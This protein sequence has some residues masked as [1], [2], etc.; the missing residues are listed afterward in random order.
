MKRPFQFSLGS[1]SSALIFESAVGRSTSFTRQCA[2]SAGALAAA[3]P[4]PR[5]AGAGAAPG[6]TNGPE[7]VE[8]AVIA[9]CGVDMA[10]SDS[11]V[12]AG[13]AA[14]AADRS[15]KPRF[16]MESPSSAFSAD[17]IE[18]VDAAVEI[19]LR[20]EEVAFAVHGDAVWCEYESGTPLVRLHL[21]GADALLGVDADPLHDLAG[22]VEHRHATGEFSD[23][24][25]F[26]LDRDRGRQQQVGGDDAEQL[27]G[28]R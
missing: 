17:H 26:A 15:T 21:V 28:E 5:A 16:N 27:A 24:R 25:V 22:L 2:G 20:D 8:A 11:H 18:A 6:A 7:G 23:D 9:T 3:G 4:P 12:V 19:E 1:H 13:A 14:A 10:C